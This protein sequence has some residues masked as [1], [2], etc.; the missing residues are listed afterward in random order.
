MNKKRIFSIGLALV[1]MVAMGWVFVK[2]V[3]ATTINPNGK[4]GSDQVIDDDLVVGGET[5]Q[6]DGTVNGTV[7]AAGSTITLNGTIN[8]DLIACGQT[9]IL[10]DAAVV[11][12]NVFA[13][14]RSVTINGTIQ[15]SLFSGSAETVL[16]PV[17]SVARN[18]Y[19]GGYS[20]T[21]QSGS[22]IGADLR[23]GQYQ[24]ILH[25]EIKRDAVLNAGAI[26]LY[27]KIDRNA[28][29]TLAGTSR[30]QNS[31]FMGSYL[32]AAVEPGLRVDPSAQITGK[33]SYVAPQKYTIAVQPGGG[34][35]YTTPAPAEPSRPAFVPG[36]IS[37][38]TSVGLG[39]WHSLST[40]LTLLI[41]GALALGLFS[42]CFEST[43]AVAQKRTLA[44]AGVGLLALVMAIPAFVMAA[45][46]IVI[47]GLFLS[48]V[49]LGGLAFPIFGLG[50]SALGLLGVTFV[51]LISVVSKLIV[52]YLVGELIFKSAK[53]NL[54]GGWQKALP[55]LVGVA[56]YAILAALP[57]VGWIFSFVA[58]CIGLGTIWFWLV[59]GKSTAPAQPPL[60]DVR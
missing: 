16:G 60:P 13:C 57:F 56:I 35:V 26:E 43:V 17:A 29:F 25:G 54:N 31:Q 52:A 2:P 21:S 32:P 33:L 28:Q 10:S 9:L 12:G 40:L 14:A 45:M 58:T 37:R 24:A 46:L 42:H 20:F 6:L 36:R 38:E 30:P 3:Q 34:I 5:V 55:L 7:I 23:G 27:G 1:L 47:V 49:S 8:G 11:S 22:V 39:A 44:S 50:F 51:V 15:G 19:F 48:L 41:A 59:P 4:V 53:A 18:V